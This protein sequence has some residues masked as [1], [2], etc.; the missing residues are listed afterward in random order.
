MVYEGDT[1]PR[2][3]DRI[4]RIAGVPG[5]LNTLSNTHVNAH[6]SVSD[7]CTCSHT[8]EIEHLCCIGIGD[9]PVHLLMFKDPQTSSRRVPTL[10]Y[11]E[12]VCVV[13][14]SGVFT[15]KDDDLWV[16][17]QQVG[18]QILYTVPEL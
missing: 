2:V 18:G 6:V 13:P 9:K 8:H 10:D 4:K 16:G 1:V 11:Q 12:V 17:S 5:E 3:V 14:S 15:L 7:T